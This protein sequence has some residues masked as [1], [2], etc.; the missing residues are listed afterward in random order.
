MTD[1]KQNYTIDEIALLKAGIDPRTCYESVQCAVDR[2]LT[3]YEKAESYLEQL[4]E[5]I[6]AG[7]LQPALV[8][9]PP[10]E[11][12][13]SDEIY[14]SVDDAENW[15]P[16][17]GIPSKQAKGEELSGKS[18]TTHLNLEKAFIKLIIEYES[19]RRP[20]RGYPHEHILFED[21]NLNAEALKR[22]LQEI[23]EETPKRADSL[24]KK[25]LES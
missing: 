13:G 6:E 7:I 9:P 23:C 18:L 4:W 21:G 5:Q 24:I 19:G 16:E 3:G 17:Q 15:Q 20:P 10:D 25:A 11:E 1:T 2:K 14:L 8:M 12:I 22:L